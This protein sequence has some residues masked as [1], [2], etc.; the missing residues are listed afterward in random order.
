MAEQ[1]IFFTDC[2][3]SIFDAIAQRRAI[4][5]S[6]NRNSTDHAWLYKKMA[7]A[8][9]A[10]RN[11]TN[12]RTSSLTTPTG[13]GLG[14][15][16]LY[17]GKTPTQEG[18]FLPKPHINT[19]KVSNEGDFG[20]IKKCEVAFTVYSRADLDKMQSFF[21]IG[22]DLVVQYGWNNAG[23]AGGKPGMFKGVVYNFG[24][25]VNTAGG[26]DCTTYGI[27]P[28]IAALAGNVNAASD[29]KGKKVTDPLGNVVSYNSLSEALSILKSDADQLQPGA[30]NADAVG[31]VKMPSSWGTASESTESKEA[32]QKA[33]DASMYF[34]SLEKIVQLVNRKVL[35]DAG[36]PRMDNIVIKCNGTISLGNIPSPD[37]LVSASPKEILFPGLCKYGANHAFTFGDFDAKFTASDP[38]GDLSKTMINIDYL[39]DTLTKIGEST[40]DKSKSADSTIAKFFKILFDRIHYCS[41]TRFKLALAT[42]AKGTDGQDDSEFLVVDTNYI[43]APL[44]NQILELTAVTEQSVCRAIS[45]SAKIPSE[46]VTMAYVQNT[47]TLSTSSSTGLSAVVGGG[48]K[49]QP[50]AETAK[51]TLQECLL[52]FDSAEVTAKD[53]TSLQAALKRVYVGGNDPGSKPSKEAIPYPIDFSATIDGLEG[54]VFGN[55]ITTNYLPSVYADKTGTKVAF[56]ITKVEHTIANNDW[57]TSLSTVCRLIPR[58]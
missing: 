32:T 1:T 24:Y 2:E 28:G 48:D 11:S 7:Y 13:A 42:N 57:T 27:G 19:V 3:K 14:G 55:A 4:Y 58:A 50:G 45:L 38:G 12:Q 31:C 26:F 20:S 17:R 41:G 34:V 37:Y 49:P 53:I 21:D 29:S 18:R 25:Q 56:T 9:A 35:R 10:A 30:V 51:P 52:K 39:I 40:Q 5:G 54:F 15:G 22:A 46:M 8:T 6:E 16:G 33:E 47:S 44:K 23:P 43:A 36:G